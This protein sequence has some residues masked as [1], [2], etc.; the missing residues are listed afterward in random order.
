MIVVSNSHSC[1]LDEIN[2]NNFR[3]RITRKRQ[4]PTP[5]LLFVSRKRRGVVFSGKNH[6]VSSAMPSKMFLGLS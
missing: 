3:N 6:D 1:N 2:D 5:G 4:V